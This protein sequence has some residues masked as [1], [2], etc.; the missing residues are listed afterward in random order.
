MGCGRLR[1]WWSRKKQ[2]ASAHLG[3]GLGAMC[4]GMWG[5]RGLIVRARDSLREKECMCERHGCL[6][7]SRVSKVR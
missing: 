7:V 6:C 4:Y 5:A 3:F 1:G 2:W